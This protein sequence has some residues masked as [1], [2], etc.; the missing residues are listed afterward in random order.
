MLS[1]LNDAAWFMVLLPEDVSNR[2][3]QKIPSMQNAVACVI[4][5]TRSCDHNFTPMLHQLHWHPLATESP[6]D[7]RLLCQSMSG[8]APVYL[9]D[10]VQFCFVHFFEGDRRQLCSSDTRTCVKH[11]HTYAHTHTQQLIMET[12]V[13]LLHDCICGT[14]TACHLTCGNQTFTTTISD[15]S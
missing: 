12:E 8:H 4:A 6:S 15:A 14:G 2:L 7:S 1:L 10:D 3:V 5:G 13:F 9:P 11:I